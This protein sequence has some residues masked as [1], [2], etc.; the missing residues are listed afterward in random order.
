MDQLANI[1]EGLDQ[2]QAIVALFVC[3]FAF[4]AVVIGLSALLNSMSSKGRMAL[5]FGA[6]LV[7]VVWLLVR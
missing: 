1:L 6:A 3:L 4:C 2:D 7:V 5:F